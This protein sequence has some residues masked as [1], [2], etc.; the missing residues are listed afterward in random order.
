[1][2]ELFEALNNL[3]ASVF[4]FG[5]TSKPKAQGEVIKLVNQECVGEGI[6]IDYGQMLISLWVMLAEEIISGAITDNDTGHTY[7]E[8]RIKEGVATFRHSAL[9]EAI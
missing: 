2:D 4:L 6:E 5:E 9:A 8:E 7:V 3:A 1:M